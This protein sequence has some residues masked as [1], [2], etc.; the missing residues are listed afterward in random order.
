MW[1][2]GQLIIWDL[3][4][5]TYWF[6][7]YALGVGIIDTIVLYQKR[8]SHSIICVGAGGISIHGCYTT[9]KLT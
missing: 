7:I 2:E 3:R 4:F 8:L 5:L 1:S 9:I 6:H